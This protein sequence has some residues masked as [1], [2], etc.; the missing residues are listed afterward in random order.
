MFGKSLFQIRISWLRSIVDSLC[1]SRHTLEYY[2]KLLTVALELFAV[3]PFDVIITYA[4]ANVVLNTFK[5]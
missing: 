1:S 3:L 4:D 5:K 2:R